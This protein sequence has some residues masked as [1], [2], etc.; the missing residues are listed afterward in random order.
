MKK[1]ISV[2]HVSKTRDVVR[3]IYKI[4]GW[5]EPEGGKIPQK[6]VPVDQFVEFPGPDEPQ[7]RPRTGQQWPFV[8]CLVP[9][10]PGADFV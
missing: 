9:H 2:P 8:H 10:G 1:D 3:G 6:L 4:T 7:P 5:S